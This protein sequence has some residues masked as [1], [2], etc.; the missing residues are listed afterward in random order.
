MDVCMWVRY[1][2][3]EHD[4]GF[5]F[6]VKRNMSIKQV[7]SL[8]NN[9]TYISGMACMKTIMRRCGH[10]RDIIS[11]VINLQNIEIFFQN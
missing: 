3:D 6:H 9:E 11:G 1:A 4:L 5:A 10:Q 8:I 2:M 7:T